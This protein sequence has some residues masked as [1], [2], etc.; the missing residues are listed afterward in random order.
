MT[1][2]Q[3]L[4]QFYFHVIEFHLHTVCLLYTSQIASVAL[5]EARSSAA[6][7]ANKG[8]LTPATEFDGDF[9]KY[10]YH[11]D[12]NIYKNRVF[13]S[14]GV[15]DESVEIQFGPNIKDW[16]AMGCLLYTSCF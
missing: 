5:M 12:S 16:P 8:V 2:F 14:H 7:A 15:A 4:V 9:G 3:V 1:A 13:D 11:F 10:K 6:T